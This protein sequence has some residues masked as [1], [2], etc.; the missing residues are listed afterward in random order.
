MATN[1]T[2]FIGGSSASAYSSPTKTP[3]SSS[4]TK[5]SAQSTDTSNNLATTASDI[6]P[7]YQPKTSLNSPY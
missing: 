2:G 3:G 4:Q 6:Y 5:S 1:G 7:A